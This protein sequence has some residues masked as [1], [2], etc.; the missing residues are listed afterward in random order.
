MPEKIYDD[1]QL[2]RVSRAYRKKGWTSKERFAG[3]AGYDRRMAFSFFNKEPISAEAFRAFCTL[4]DLDWEEIAGLSETTLPNSDSESA[5]RRAT[6]K[7]TISLSSQPIAN[8][9]TN[10]ESEAIASQIREA[11]R[12]TIQEYRGFVRILDMQKRV[13]LEQIYVDVC[14]LKRDNNRHP[15]QEKKLSETT[16]NIDATFDVFGWQSLEL[17]ER[18][19]GDQII[20]DD[21]CIMILGKPG[22]GKTTFLKQLAVRCINQKIHSNLIPIFIDLKAFSAATEQ[23]TLKHYIAEEIANRI[24]IDELNESERLLKRLLLEGRFLFLFDAVDEVRQEHLERVREGISA[25]L[26]LDVKCKNRFVITCR[27][28]AKYF[29]L[30]HFTEVTLADFDATQVYQFAEKWFRDNDTTK[31]F[32][33][34]LSKYPR[35]RELART[36]LLL[37]L[38]CLVFRASGTFPQKRV[39]LYK[40]GLEILLEGWDSQRNVKRDET[41]HNLNKEQ[42]IKLLRHIARTNFEQD[43]CRFEQDDLVRQI[44]EFL[45]SDAH[46][47]RDGN[48]VLKAIEAHHGLFVERTHRVYTFSHL[49]FQE[50]LTACWFAEQYRLNGDDSIF[51][52]AS[53]T[54]WTEVLRLLTEILPSETQLLGETDVS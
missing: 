5:P 21:R 10:I 6:P 20:Q 35:M 7:T 51:P 38:Q 47:F 8:S 48:A 26:R 31:R 44:E 17:G 24:G 54:R 4:L 37:T 15:L 50:Y 52:H 30:E 40:E 28:G 27:S 41:Y 9:E 45:N 16:E 3:Q 1:S 46:T 36:P 43:K 19:S 2:E 53:E 42:K 32:E 29:F 12:P 14:I 22:A 49:T 34:E 25:L 39:D 23:P 13:S 11:I 18:L 33:Q